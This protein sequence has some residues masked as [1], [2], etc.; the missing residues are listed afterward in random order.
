MANCTEAFIVIRWINFIK[1]IQEAPYPLT[2]IDYR[3]IV[4]IMDLYTDIECL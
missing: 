2:Q 4:P 1:H 3:A